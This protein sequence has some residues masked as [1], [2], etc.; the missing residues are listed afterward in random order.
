MMLAKLSPPL[1]GREPFRSRRSR[2]PA[3]Y[4]AVAMSQQ[5]V[6]IV[7]A[8]FE[9]WNAGDM[10]A[11]REM[12]TPDVILRHLE[13]WPEPG[14]SVGRDATMQQF[15]GMREAFDTDALKVISDF[16][17]IGDRVVVR[18]VWRGA[19]QGPDANLEATTI[20]TV[21]NRRIFEQEFL[22]DH[23]EALAAVGLTE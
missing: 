8:V 14:P 18:F 21:R 15:A 20:F 12:Y 6:E 13:G 3:R 4:W 1:L 10:D 9:A 17:D 2:L 11:F 7:R 19:G 23:A 5:N 22:W 16:V